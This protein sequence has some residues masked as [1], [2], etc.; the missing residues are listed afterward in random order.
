L[1]QR[2]WHEVASFN[3]QWSLYHRADKPVK[4]AYGGF[5]WS[6]ADFAAKMQ[7][8]RERPALLSKPA[9]SLEPGSYRGYLPPTAMEEIAGMLCWGGF[10]GRALATRQSCLFKMQDGTAGLD[11]SISFSENTA[12]GVAPAFQDEG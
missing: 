4:T 3:L 6:A 9:R 12:D 11:R 1:G 10:S 7:G 5:A 2:N 8:A